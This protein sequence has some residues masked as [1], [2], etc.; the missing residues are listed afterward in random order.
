MLGLELSANFDSFPDELIV[1]QSLENFCIM[2]HN[3]WL[4]RA[5]YMTHKLFKFNKDST[6]PHFSPILL[7]LTYRMMTHSLDFRYSMA[8]LKTEKKVN[9]S[10][11]I[12]K[13]VL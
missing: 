1:S 6:S 2:T 12:S 10:L 8:I 13:K 7:V 5:K 4:R 11:Q 9:S 3:P